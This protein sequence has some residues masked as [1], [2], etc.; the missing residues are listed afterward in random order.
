MIET[1]WLTAS[2]GVTVGARSSGDRGPG[3]IFVH[4]V[5]ST[6]AI[7][8]DQLTAFSPR[9][10]CFAIEL[11]GNGAAAKD[12]DPAS[13]TRAGFVQDVLTVADDADLECFHFV[14]CSLGGVV[15]FELWRRA[16]ER[17]AS[18]TFVDSFAVY[19]NAEQTAQ[20][21]IDAATAAGNLRDFAKARAARVLAPNAPEK[22][23]TETIEQ[24]AC[25]SIPSYVASTR[26]TWG[27]DY[28]KDLPTITVPTLVICGELDPIAPLALSKEIADG[29]PGAKLAVVP[30]ANHVC[31]ADAPERFN[32]LL[33]PFL[34]DALRA[35]VNVKSPAT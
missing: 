17:V 33:D 18:L 11:R 32:A 4:G 19:P 8:D 25:K 16:K 30:G 14:G 1:R 15:G 28:R 26:A 2:D 22:R 31:N 24:Y 6:A 20:S 3:L 27:G 35:A 12:P 7:W 34:N 10:R 23:Y 21:I 5:G 29:I 13:I 9:Y